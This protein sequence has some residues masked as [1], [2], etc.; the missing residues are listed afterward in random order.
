MDLEL[1]MYVSGATYLGFPLQLF[2][3]LPGSIVL[4]NVSSA[5]KRVLLNR[6]DW[7]VGKLVYGLYR[8][9]ARRPP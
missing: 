7:K 6:E 1:G 2:E 3:S 9:E 4:S 5:T 8:D